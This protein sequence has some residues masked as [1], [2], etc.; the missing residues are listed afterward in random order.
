MRLPTRLAALLLA[1]LLL[2]P[3]VPVTPASADSADGAIHIANAEDFASFARSCTLDSWSRGRTFILDADLTLEDADYLPVPTF[4]G[5]FCGNGHTIRAFSITESLS[6]AG[7]FGVLQEG[8]SITGLNAEGSVTP[9]G[10]SM[11]VG[12]IAGENRGLIEK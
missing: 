9:A 6:P 12:G 10:D 4:G 2:V 1:L 5:T 8:G 3:L 7:L 11:N